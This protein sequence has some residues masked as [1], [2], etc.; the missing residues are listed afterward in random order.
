MAGRGVCVLRLQTMAVQLRY[1]TLIELFEQSLARAELTEKP[2]LEVVTKNGQEELTF[3]ELRSKAREFAVHLI[4]K[5]AVGVGDKV[6]VLGRNRVDWD[7]A[8]WG[9]ILAGAVPVLIDPQRRIEGVKNHLLHTDARMLVL[10]DD[11]QP[12]G[13]REKLREFLT[14]RGIDLIEMTVYEKP[15]LEDSRLTVLLNKTRAAIKADDTAVILCTSGTTGDPREVEITH[16]NLIANIQGALDVVSISAADK[17]GHIIPPHHSFGLTVAKLLPLW[18]G[19][20]NL[21]TDKY[22]QI[23]QLI[24][25]KAVTIFVGVPA[26]FIVLAR[27]IEQN[28]AARKEK[29]FFVRLADR[30]LPGLV[31]RMMVKK[32]GWG[33]LRFFLS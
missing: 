17:L 31:G 26:V 10:A 9:I 20:T 4:Q 14:G 15:S 13:S 2:C 8:F 29:S 30:Y 6:A 3:G 21:Y 11:Y 23:S 27:K 25:D 24:K 32:L 5:R 28:L 1:R 12:D 22:R 19:A 18:V 16:A 33:T 7:V